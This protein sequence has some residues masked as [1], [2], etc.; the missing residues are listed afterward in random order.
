MELLFLSADAWRPEGLE[1]DT[2]SLL[3]N[4]Q[5]MVDTGWHPV[6]NLIREG[7]R[8]EDVKTLLFTHLHQDH[9]IGLPAILFWLLNSHQAA[10]MLE[11]MGIEGT[12]EITRMALEY[13]GKS[14]YY[15]KAPAPA[16]RTIAPGDTFERCGLRIETAPS[17][18]AVPGIMYRFT[19]AEGHVLV[20][21]G[22]TEPHEDTL[23]LA[24]GADVLIHEH[25][26]GAKTAGDNHWGHSG[27]EDAAEI[28]KEA[29]VGKLFLVH[30]DPAFIA[31]SVECARRIF[32]D[33]ERAYSGL[34]MT[35]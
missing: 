34:K 20:Y 2:V 10:D 12:E 25:S 8:P 14:T 3:L 32:P 27:A 16:V 24:K 22:D 21:S 4:G 18:H 19:D 6:H 35:L 33:T 23:R 7:Y 9:R 11:I 29:G 28:A 31:E 15:E 1:S 17:H 30:S 26:Y 13:A 5:L